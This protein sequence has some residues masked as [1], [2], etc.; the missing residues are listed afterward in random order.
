MLNKMSISKYISLEVVSAS[1]SNGDSDSDSDS[2]GN[3]GGNSGRE[4][5]DPAA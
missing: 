5:P 3:P 4:A 2:G 1:D